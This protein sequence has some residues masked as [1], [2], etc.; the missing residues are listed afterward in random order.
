M[1]TVAD[2]RAAVQQQGD[3]EN[4]PHKG[5]AEIDAQIVR[6]FREGWATM[7]KAS[8]YYFLKPA[9]FSLVGGV[10]AQTYDLATNVT[11]F[12]EAY[13]LERDDGSGEYPEVVWPIDVLE[14]HE[15]T[16]RGWFIH[17]GTLRVEPAGSAAGS[18]RLWYVYKPADPTATIVDP[19]GLLE[20]FIIDTVTY[21]L[22][23]KEEQASAELK[24]L[25]DELKAEVRALAG[26]RMFPRTAVDVGGGR[27]FRYMTRREPI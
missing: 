6:A 1:A 4:D 17:D 20:Q 19:T 13:K 27:R 15:R 11:D 16:G 21:R 18:Y 23:L 7:L 12:L 26:A 25:R 2:V 10:A 24:T 8:R 22:S 9:T 14:R 5:T 3:F